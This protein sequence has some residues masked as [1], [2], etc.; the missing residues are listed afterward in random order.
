MWARAGA[1]AGG[2][3]SLP[4]D[5]LWAWV[6]RGMV[7]DQRVMVSPPAAAAGWAQREVPPRPEGQQGVGGRARQVRQHAQL[8]RLPLPWGWAP[9]GREAQPARLLGFVSRPGARLAA[10]CW[11]RCRLLR[12]MRRG[13]GGSRP[14][15][16]CRGC[17]QGLGDP[18]GHAGCGLW[19]RVGRLAHRPHHLHSLSREVEAPDGVEQVR[20]EVGAGRAQRRGGGAVC[21]DAISS[22]SGP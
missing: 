18:A 21:G 7:L 1:G 20:P 13:L 2:C 4:S 12:A 5:L 11:R 6:L 19:L 3:R 10:R 17:R 16:G 14:H 22:L 8:L 9:R 15:A